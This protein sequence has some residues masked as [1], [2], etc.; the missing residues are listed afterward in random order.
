MIPKKT[1]PPARELAVLDQAKANRDTFPA[2]T[3]HDLDL[4]ELI[5]C[6]YTYAAETEHKWIKHIFFFPT[7]WIR[8]YSGGQNKKWVGGS[9]IELEPYGN[10]SRQDWGQTKICL[11]SMV[12]GLEN[13]Y[14]WL[15][16]TFRRGTIDGHLMKKINEGLSPVCK[17]NANVW[18]LMSGWKFRDRRPEVFEGNCRWKLMDQEPQSIAQGWQPE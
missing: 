16:R 9:K 18:E 2:E 4:S 1:Y 11:K 5:V 14:T 13:L 6:N 7:F 17:I 10:I 3:E 15:E 12:L 8:K